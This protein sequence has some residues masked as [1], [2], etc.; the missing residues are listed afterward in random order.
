MILR[1]AG[2]IVVGS[3]FESG[4]TPSVMFGEARTELKWGWRHE[5]NATSETSWW[6]HQCRGRRRAH[7]HYP[8]ARHRRGPA[9]GRHF[10]NVALAHVRRAVPASDDLSDS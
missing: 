9:R 7:G 5:R 4:A 10:P 3:R 6:K 2:W 1:A 8:F